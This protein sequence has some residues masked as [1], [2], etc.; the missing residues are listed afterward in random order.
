M[1]S[2]C[3]IIAEVAQAHDGSL[4]MA[5]AFVDAAHRAGADA[6]KFQMHFAA[7]ESTPSEP[8]RIKFSKQDASRYEYWRRMEFTESQWFELKAHCDEVGIQFICSPFSLRAVELL[9]KIGM[10]AWKV[11][12]GEVFGSQMFDAMGE[13]RWPMMVSTGMIGWDEIRH[14][15]KK[16]KDRS[17]DLTLF[18]CTSAYPTPP[19]RVGL[20]VIEQFRQEFGC[21]VGLSDHSGQIFAGLAAASLGIN[22]LEV[23]MTWHRGCFGPDVSASLTLE[24]LS[25]LVQGVRSIETMRA[26]PVNKDDLASEMGGMRSLFSKSLVVRRPIPAGKVIDATDLIL[27]KPG[28][29]LPESRIGEIV[30]RV[31]QRDLAT[32][33]LILEKD[34]A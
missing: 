29:G 1:E 8:W 3:L 6:V 17:L 31:A 33:D 32:D 16:V 20:N 28:T 27:K 2:S 14:V 7:E 11:A 30:G 26:N 34:V 24:E 18:Q 19:E 25:I 10:P 13:T 5:H 15:V 9:K 21:N 12:S 4:G 23:H 22:A